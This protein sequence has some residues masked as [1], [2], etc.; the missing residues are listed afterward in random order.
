M[1]KIFRTLI[2][3]SYLAYLMW[4]F[5]PYYETWLLTDLMREMLDADGYNGYDFLL[6]NSL[7]IGWFF[8]VA[9]LATSIGLYF[10]IKPARTLFTILFLTSFFLPMFFCMSVQSH[11]DVILNKIIGFSDDLIL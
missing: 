3:V 10:Y 11:I 6:K 8:L 1:D 9:Y 5:Q 4:F 7:H 2:V